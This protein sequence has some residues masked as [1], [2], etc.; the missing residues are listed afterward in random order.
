[1]EIH[2][3]IKRMFGCKKCRSK[4]SSTSLK[5][6]SRFFKVLGFKVLGNELCYVCKQSRDFYIY[7][8]EFKMGWKKTLKVFWVPFLPY[9]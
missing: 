8:L 2:K 1:M 7:Y 4:I 5:M 3:S 6:Q 9:V